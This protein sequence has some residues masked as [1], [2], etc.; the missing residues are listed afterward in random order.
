MADE[1]PVLR[2]PT[3]SHAQNFSLPKIG[4]LALCGLMAY[5][6]F[7]TRQPYDKASI[8]HS[9]NSERE[10]QVMDLK[11][12]NQRLAVEAA[13]LGTDR[14]MERQL[15]LNGFTKQNEVPLLVF[16]K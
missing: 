10:K 3:K 7:V 14:G 12:K 11:V 5:V 16:D 4:M 2:L 15:R 6:G 13:E 9:T 1:S 8:L